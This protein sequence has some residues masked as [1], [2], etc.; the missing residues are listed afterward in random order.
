MP[1]VRI[2]SKATDA[3][4]SVEIKVAEA[5]TLP[6]LDDAL[7]IQLCGQY[8]RSNRG[9]YGI[10]LLVHQNARPVGWEDRANGV[11]L[12]FAE[13]VARLRAR[14]SEISGKSH[15]APQPEIAVLDVATC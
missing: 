10:L 4:V 3:N 5:W 15:D 8:L 6:D 13:V 9:R 12:T 14:A 11:F 2:R 7:E 1:D